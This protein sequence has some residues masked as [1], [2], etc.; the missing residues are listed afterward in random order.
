MTALKLIFAII[1][2]TVPLIVIV[3]AFRSR[4]EDRWPEGVLVGVYLGVLGSIS[5]IVLLAFFD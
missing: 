4:A 1:G 2:A 3:Q 5:V